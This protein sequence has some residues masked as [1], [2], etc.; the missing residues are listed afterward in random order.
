MSATISQGTTNPTATPTLA[1]SGRRALITLAR[2]GA[3]LAVLFLWLSLLAFPDFVAGDE[4]DPSWAQ[5][6]N[7]FYTHGYQAGVDYIFTFGPLGAFATR[8]YDADVFW[9]RYA[10]EI[11]VK[12]CVALAI[13]TVLPARRRVLFAVLLGLF[14]PLHGDGVYTV[15]ILAVGAAL[16]DDRPGRRGVGNLLVIP[17]A[18]VALTKLTCLVAAFGVVVLGEMALRI[19]APRALYSPLLL[20]LGALAGAW[21]LAGQGIQNVARFLYA[22]FEIT[23]GY[24]SAMSLAGRSDEL[25]LALIVLALVAFLLVDQFRRH[26]RAR[27]APTLLIAAMLFLAWKHGFVRQET[28]TH[29]RGFFLTALVAAMLLSRDALAGP[30][31]AKLVGALLALACGA[32]VVLTTYGET[33]LRG[34]AAAPFGRIVLNARIAVQPE[35]RKEAL[36]THKAGLEQLG[37]LTNISAAVG[38]ARVDMI[39]FQQGVVLLNHWNWRPRP[40]FQSYSAY[41][42]FLLQAN[43]AYFAADD[44]PDYVIVRLA[45]IDARAPFSEDG[46]ALIELLRRYYPVLSERRYFLFKHQPRATTTPPSDWK[47]V[48]ERTVRFG[49]EVTLDKATSVLTSATIRV[50]PSLWGKFRGIVYRT[51]PLRMHVRTVSGRVHVYRVVPALAEAGFLLSPLVD[52][53][54]DL[55]LLYQARSGERVESFSITADEDDGEFLD[56]IE[57]VLS[58]TSSLPCRQNL[59]TRPN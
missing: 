15:F 24:T 3:V 45:P 35:A 23:R 25:I 12:F 20:F 52:E 19:R 33:D 59:T 29:A 30:L 50:R 4:L 5:A 7:Y 37:A 42:P 47:V 31:L 54:E 32:G 57:I 49:E 48:M 8:A 55:A 26:G 41:T 39:S 56:D 11:V 53:T 40:V 51:A 44:A 16:L 22:S 14:L 1:G 34:Y 9:Q 2:I 6:L 58:S 46:P 10:W 13:V 43:A 21:T 17:L 38:A 18:C 28:V 27:L 36:D